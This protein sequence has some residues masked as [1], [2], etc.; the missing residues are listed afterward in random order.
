MVRRIPSKKS[1]GTY[2][3]YEP[4]IGAAKVSCRHI[5]ADKHVDN[6]YKEYNKS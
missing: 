6:L 2:N 4:Q 5:Y 3:N 1:Y